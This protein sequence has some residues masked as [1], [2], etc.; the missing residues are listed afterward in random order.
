ML[1]VRI[2]GLERRL[3]HSPEITRMDFKIVNTL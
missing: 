2:R 3:M 1:V